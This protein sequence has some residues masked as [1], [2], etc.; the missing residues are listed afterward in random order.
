MKPK[1]GGKPN[2]ELAKKIEA[3]FGSVDGFLS[4]FATVAKTVSGSGWAVLA[5]EPIAKRLVISGV[6]K[7]ENVDVSGSIPLLVCDVWEHAYY[8]KY[9]NRRAEYVDAF[10]A[11]LVNHFPA[12]TET[13]AAGT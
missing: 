6:E 13:C 12:V 9:Q 7:H 8:L 10:M 1:G 5:Y 4:A 2:G 3:D 11:N